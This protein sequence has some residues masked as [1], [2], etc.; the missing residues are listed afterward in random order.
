MAIDVVLKKNTAFREAPQLQ[1]VRDKIQAF[2]TDPNNTI[3]Q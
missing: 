1:R 2:L 3:T